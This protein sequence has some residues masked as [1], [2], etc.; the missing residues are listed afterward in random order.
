MIRSTIIAAIFC[1][2]MAGCSGKEAEV[3]EPADDQP[4]LE[5]LKTKAVS[6]TPEPRFESYDDT[7]LED[8]IEQTPEVLSETTGQSKI[9]ALPTLPVTIKMHDI[10]VAV[11]IRTL[12]R[13]ADLDIMI[14]D[15]IQG[16]AKIA[17]TDVPW[18]KAF[19]GILDTYG[20]TYEW[21][22]DI[23]RVLSVADLQKKQALMEAK[24][25]FE[26]TRNNHTLAV[27]A[28]EEASKRLQPL[29][30]KVVQIHYADLAEL[31]QNLTQYLSP[32][33]NDTE[34]GTTGNTDPM[35][36]LTG[37][38]AA[39]TQP[40][41]QPN[42]SPS[43]SILMDTFSNSLILHATREDI[44]K[45]LP[46]I[47]QIDR[48]TR[49]ILIEAHIVEAESNTGRELGVQWGG[50]GTL[51][52]N[53]GKGISIGGNM[54]EAGSSLE[55]GYT[56]TDGN[57]VNLPLSE[58]ASGTGM[59]LG[60]MAQKAGEFVLYTQ[61]LA[62]EREGK[63][64]ILS[65]PSI[66]TLD[67]QKATIKSGREVPY[68]TVVDDDI[69]IEWKEAVVKLEVTPHIVNNN[70]VRLEIV[71][72]KDELDF[73]N[74]VDGNPT[75]ITKNAE[76]NVMLFDGQTTVIG[77]LNKENKNRNENGVP[78]AKDVPGL[79]W[80]FKS[81][82]KSRN[83]EEL[84]IFITPRILKGVTEFNPDTHKQAAQ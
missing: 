16:Q 80:L 1:I 50:L 27:L 49:Q 18:D 3:Q 32:G 64:N 21:S 73:I 26:Q 5:Q 8:S 6:L 15:S 48:P 77:G 30:T 65:Q 74:D 63:L 28:Q 55:D 71:T 78:G 12:A 4:V 56:A 83:M 22:G 60:L 51:D 59:T 33:Q 66:T 45:L 62:L 79:G 13:I 36:A 61:L 44:R 41:S 84:L 10:P 82:A 43:G 19:K 47:R 72:H 70:I 11:L 58:A 46:I 81:K 29:V 76:T 40:T 17:I 34:A 14:T 24:Q 38:A 57:I 25:N 53:S 75:V 31:Q 2:L 54:A 69:S 23:I 37:E 9:H 52:G 20:L 7:V 42:D 67:H 68:Q 39:A 35:S